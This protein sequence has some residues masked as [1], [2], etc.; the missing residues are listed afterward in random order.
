V[1]QD[2][3]SQGR[4]RELALERLQRRLI[5]ALAVQPPRRPTKP[6]QAAVRRRLEAKRRQAQ[7]KR[8]RGRPDAPD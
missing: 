5:G 2:E 3:R 7:R 4:N 8:E 6:T 1:A